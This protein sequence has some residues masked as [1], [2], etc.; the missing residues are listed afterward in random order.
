MSVSQHC[1][2][3]QEA[4]SLK[5]TTATPPSIQCMM[6][7]MGAQLGKGLGKNLQGTVAPPAAV[8]QTSKAGLEKNKT[9]H[10]AAGPPQ[11][12][13]M[14]YE[15]TTARRQFW[16]PWRKERPEPVPDP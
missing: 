5:A 12:D 10:R 9:A 8:G 2:R 13:L 1:I 16:L 15:T 4:V 7:L 14:G 3:L 11:Q 6:E